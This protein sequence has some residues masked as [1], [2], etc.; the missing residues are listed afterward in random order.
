MTG[1][2]RR[3]VLVGFMGS[4]KTTVGA[5]LARILGWR[6]EDMDVRISAENGLSVAEIFGRRG[7]A[8]F[9]AEE[10]RVAAALRGRERLVVA[11][12]GGAFATPATREALQA[13]A[14]AVWLKC[15]LETILARVPLDG[16]RPLASSRETIGRLL[17]EREPSYRLADLTVDASGRLPEAV[18]REIVDCLFAGQ[19]A[20][21]RGG[22]P[23]R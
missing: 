13:G 17:A 8:F 5:S 16:S 10:A 3:I 18:A 11:A 1:P 4:G 6:F 21:G 12:G 2:P 15:D 22:R 7:E 14:A 19:A 20:D 9:R 23:N